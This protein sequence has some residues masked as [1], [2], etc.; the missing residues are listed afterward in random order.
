MTKSLNQTQLFNNLSELLSVVVSAT[1]NFPKSARYVAG[2]EMQRCAVRMLT[3]F[4]D[5]YTSNDASCI[6][7]MANLIANMQTL[8]VMVSVSMQQRWIYG[9]KKAG[10]LIRLLDSISIQATALRNSFVSRFAKDEK[11]GAYETKVSATD[12]SSK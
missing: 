7:T 10:R 8:K 1:E 12:A 6:A 11:S 9:Q 3:D 4:A 5:A 2:A